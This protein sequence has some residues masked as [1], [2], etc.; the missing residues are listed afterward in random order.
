MIFCVA[1]THKPNLS[2]RAATMLGKLQH[3]FG[4]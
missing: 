1:L 3:C 4:Y 2:H